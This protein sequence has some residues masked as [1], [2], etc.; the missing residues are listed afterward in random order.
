MPNFTYILGDPTGQQNVTTLG[1][2]QNTGVGQNITVHQPSRYPQVFRAGSIHLP[3]DPLRYL[4]ID[5]VK[6]S[7]T[8]VQD[9]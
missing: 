2:S 8:A 7:L 1:S 6:E 9:R 3:H 4:A 5:F